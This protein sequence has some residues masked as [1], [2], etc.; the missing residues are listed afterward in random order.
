MG[1][2]GDFVKKCLDLVL[3]DPKILENTICSLLHDVLGTGAG[4]HPGNFRPDALAHDRIPEGAP[5]NST[6]MHF[7]YFI[8]GCTT[9]RG[10]ALHHVL[11]AHEDFCPVGILMTVQEFSCDHTAEFL[12]LVYITV[13]RLLEDFVN[14]LKVT[15]EIGSF[16]AP[17]QVYE[18]I[19]I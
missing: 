14:H 5:C 10:F 2:H 17:G 19:K 11:T 15:G 1:G 13:D 8:T 9:D 6:C 7:H 18:Y 4:C 3:A 16:Q 12:D